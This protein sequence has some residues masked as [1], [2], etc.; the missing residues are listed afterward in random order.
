MMIDKGLVGFTMALILA[1]PALAQ[2]A[3][4]GKTQQRIYDPGTKRHLIGILESIC[5]QAAKQRNDDASYHLYLRDKNGQRYLIHLGPKAFFDDHD[6]KLNVGMK[7]QIIA[8]EMDLDREKVFVAREIESGDQQVMIPDSF[9]R[10][11]YSKNRSLRSEGL[12]KLN[13]AS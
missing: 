12:K 5:E 1:D 9:D 4:R 13:N 10:P 6:L 3:S 2:I 8:Q 11:K 7:L